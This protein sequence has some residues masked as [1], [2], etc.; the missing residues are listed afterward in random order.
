MSE[1]P[2]GPLKANKAAHG[3][4]PCG[5]CGKLLKITWATRSA[6]CSCGARIAPTRDSSR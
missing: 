1:K 6:V 3:Y 5:A 2:A 4:V